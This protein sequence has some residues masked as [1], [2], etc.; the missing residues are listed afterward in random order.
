MRILTIL[1][2]ALLVIGLAP[3]VRAFTFLAI[4]G[5]SYD[6]EGWRGQ[7]VLVVNT[8]PLCDPVPQYA[9][10]EALNGTYAP[11]GLVVVAVPSDDFAEEVNDDAAVVDECHRRL[12]VDVAWTRVTSV[13]GED[14]HPFYLWLAEEYGVEPTWNFNKVLIGPEGEFL[15]FWTS[16]TRLDSPE[17]T[18]MIEAHLPR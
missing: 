17:I 5:G 12:G 9:A 16:T 11:R 7:P 15:A 8:P 6:L 14:A 13:L 1:L 4:D 18:G 2:A 3:T 10:M